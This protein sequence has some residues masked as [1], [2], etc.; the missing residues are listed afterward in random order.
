MHM[1]SLSCTSIY[2]TAVI[3]AAA[4]LPLAGLTMVAWGLKLHRNTVLAMRPQL[5]MMFYMAV[6][7]VG[8]TSFCLAVLTRLHS[9]IGDAFAQGY[10]IAHSELQLGFTPSD[11]AD[12]AP[13]T[14]S[15]APSLR[16]VE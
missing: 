11:L 4:S 6:L 3:V 9:T 10:K 15:P 16:A 8:V 12:V 1:P 13:S 14:S 5:V 7:L 2:R